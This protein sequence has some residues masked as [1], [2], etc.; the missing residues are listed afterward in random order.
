MEGDLLP[1][2]AIAR[3]LGISPQRVRQLIDEG[4]FG[5]VHRGAYQSMRL[6][7][8]AAVEAVARERERRRARTETPRR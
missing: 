8:K 3:R 5:P 7:S 6:V 2:G 4:R 1:V